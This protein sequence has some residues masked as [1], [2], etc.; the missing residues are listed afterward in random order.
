MT[1][2]VPSTFFVHTLADSGTCT[3][4]VTFTSEGSD[5]TPTSVDPDDASSTPGATT[6]TVKAGMTTGGTYKAMATITPC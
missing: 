1:Q 3:M 5:L 2:N 6:R 4:V